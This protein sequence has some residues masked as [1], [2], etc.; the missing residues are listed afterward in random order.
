VPE[1][2]YAV[3]VGGH[4]YRVR[5]SSAG[6]EFRVTLDDRPEV[7][8]EL[9]EAAGRG[10]F[11][12]LLGHESHAA[13]VESGPDGTRVW[14][15]GEPYDVQVLDERLRSL[16]AGGGASSV[17]KDRL[18]KTP[19]PGL[20]VEVGVAA[21]EPVTKGQPLVSLESMKMRND[22]KSPH[23]GTVEEVLVVAG[24][25]VAKGEV[26]LSFED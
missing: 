5:V 19:M 22:L 12:L 21:G 26:L 25:T 17:A 1:K 4:E 2:T 24:Q 20:V 13:L 11:S 3:T 6:E 16:G 7:G 10:R 8:A 18:F 15:E 9:A 23:D 14:L